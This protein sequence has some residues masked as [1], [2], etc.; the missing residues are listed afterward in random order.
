L[1]ARLQY[2]DVST[3]HRPEAPIPD[4]PSLT[5]RILAF[6]EARDWA[7]FH[8]PRNLAA[9]LSIEAAELLELFQWDLED[10]P[11]LDSARRERIAEELADIG[12]YALLL[13]HEAGIDLGRAIAD[14]IDENERKYPVEKA[15]GRSTKYTEL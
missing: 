8:T 5:T 10:A 14:K 15:K 9:S 3:R 1:I 6:R 13:A 12:I 7:Q 4:L 2:P 11:P